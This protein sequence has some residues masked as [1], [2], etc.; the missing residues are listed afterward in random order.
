MARMPAMRH[1]Y[2]A[3]LA[4]CLAATG[5]QVALALTSS[6]TFSIASPQNGAVVSGTISITAIAGSGWVNV[7]AYYDGS[8]I[9]ADST[10]SAGK[11]TL[12]LD[13]TQLPN[14]PDTIHVMAFSVPAGQSGG[15]SSSLNLILNVSNGSVG[16]G[17]QVRTANHFLN[18][19]GINV[20]TFGGNYAGTIAGDLSN[21]TV[22]VSEINYLGVRA[23]RE[24][25]ND[26][27]RF[28]GALAHATGTKLVYGIDG[29][30]NVTESENVAGCEGANNPSSISR[31]IANITY[32]M[33]TYPGIVGWVEGPN[34]VDNWSLYYEGAGGGCV[35]AGACGH[36]GSP[37]YTP[38]ANFQRDFYSA[39]KAAFPKMPVLNLTH[40]GSEYPNVGLQYNVI[41]SGANT[42]FPAG[43]TYFDCANNH[44]YVRPSETGYAD[45]TVWDESDPYYDVGH[46][47]DPM[48]DEYVQPWAAHRHDGTNYGGMM[49]AQATSICRTSTETGWED[50]ANSDTAA[51]DLQGKVVL[52]IYL[53]QFARGWSNTWI[54]NLNDCPCAG[55][56]GYWGMFF[57]PSSGTG[58]YSAKLAATYVHNLTTILA[59]RTEF[60]PKYLNYSIPAESSIP[61][62][63]DLLLQKSNGKFELVV[64]DD[65][66]PGEATDTVVVNLGATYNEVNTYDP[67]IGTAVQDAHGSASSVTLKLSD[68]PLI[69]EIQ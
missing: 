19:M 48:H 41:P 30:W 36:P 6:R 18:S 62:V 40:G 5:A 54:Y 66:P 65:R 17:V 64:W 56:D 53:S 26:Q 25:N 33:N 49:L 46:A 67:T 24:A 38:V 15:K 3:L 51:F 11:A 7:R 16:V 60:T 52:N 4:A 69:I 1:V 32:L 29:C 12:G 63:H 55:N 21:N 14:G 50:D 37:T 58:R 42:T 28:M 39:V 22:L 44:N 9:T 47:Q 61:T 20:S 45:N 59:D 23:L 35:P 43:T 10:P 31:E 34:E 8:P 13:T 2:A 27:Y 57:Y 68:H